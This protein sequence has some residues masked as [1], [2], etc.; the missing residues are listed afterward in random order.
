[1]KRWDWSESF[2]L[3]WAQ[4]SYFFWKRGIKQFIITRRNTS[5]T[6]GWPLNHGPRS[7]FRECAS[8]PAEEKQFYILMLT[9]VSAF[10]LVFQFRWQ[11]TELK[12]QGWLRFDTLWSQDNAVLKESG[13]LVFERQIHL[14][15]NAKIRKFKI[16]IHHRFRPL[17]WDCFDPSLKKR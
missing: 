2:N 9:I 11:R 8:V 12:L 16:I 15:V 4:S 3:F 13:A 14:D 10:F 6:E 5:K 7:A 17:N 1:M